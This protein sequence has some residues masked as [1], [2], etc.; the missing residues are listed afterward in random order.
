MN[1]NDSKSWLCHYCINLFPFNHII[2]NE[3]FI[4]SSTNSDA[5]LAN[6]IDCNKLLFNPF[7]LNLENGELTDNIPCN[8][9]DPDINYYNTQ[10]QHTLIDSKYYDSSEFNSTIADLSKTTQLSMF[11]SNIRSANKNANNLSI[12][13]NKL[14]HQ[15]DIITLSETWLN[16]HNTE[17]NGF[18]EYNHIYNLRNSKKGGG[19]SILVK[20][21]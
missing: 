14:N 18:P 12:Q 9:Y 3:F 17:I 7:D 6:G 20:N 5:T 21:V 1:D 16:E 19:V 11:H 4:T 13:L 15:F 10:V 2:D 8:D